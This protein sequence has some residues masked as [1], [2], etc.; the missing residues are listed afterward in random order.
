M[1]ILSL[2]AHYC[3]SLILNT[4]VSNGVIFLGGTGFVTPFLTF[5]QGIKVIQT[6]KDELNNPS[7]LEQGELLDWFSTSF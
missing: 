4:N 7:R 1:V 6:I 5:Q 3:N 2:D